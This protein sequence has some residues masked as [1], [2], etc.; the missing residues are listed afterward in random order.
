MNSNPAQSTQ[1]HV[2]M[3]SQ[4]DSHA[5]AIILVSFMALSVSKATVLYE[6]CVAERRGRKGEQEE[7]MR[8]GGFFCVGWG[9]ESR[10]GVRSSSSR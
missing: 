1:S 3:L 10:F 6:G 9:G 7:R 4:N 8:G 2:I 5:P